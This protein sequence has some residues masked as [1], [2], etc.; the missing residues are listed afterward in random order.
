MFSNI[1]TNVGQQKKPWDDVPIE[2]LIE[3]ERKKEQARREQE[4]PRLYVPMPDPLN[5][6]KE[7]EIEEDTTIIKF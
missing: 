6:D 3:F 4:R 7:E 1:V 2:V 5:M